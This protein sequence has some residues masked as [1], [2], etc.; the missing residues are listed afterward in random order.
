MMVWFGYLFLKVHLFL[1]TGLS[2]KAM[3]DFDPPTPPLAIPADH[4]MF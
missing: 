4:R 1:P 2:S 3:L